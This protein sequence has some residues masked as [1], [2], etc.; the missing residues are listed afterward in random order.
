MSKSWY[1]GQ[2][3]RYCILH[4][5]QASIYNILCALAPIDF[6][7]LDSVNSLSTTKYENIFI[8]IHQCIINHSRNIYN[9]QF[10]RITAPLQYSIF[11]FFSEY[12][13][14]YH[15]ENHYFMIIQNLLQSHW[16][17]LKQKHLP[18]S[19]VHCTY[20]QYSA[21]WL[22]TTAE[23]QFHLNTLSVKL[24]MQSN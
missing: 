13:I 23:L 8:L 7:L 12:I 6:S 21:A 1:L 19:E 20:Y 10:F 18:A 5:W 15:M 3:L 22:C 16:I 9:K 11:Q 24:F 4:T 2:Q 17:L 14:C